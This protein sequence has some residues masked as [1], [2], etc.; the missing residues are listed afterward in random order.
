MNIDDDDDDDDG[1]GKFM[2]CFIFQIW[3][4]LIFISSLLSKNN[5]RVY[6]TV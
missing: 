5:P 6:N 2:K 1:S 4:V 3:M